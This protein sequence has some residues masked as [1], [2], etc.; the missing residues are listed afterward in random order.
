MQQACLNLWQAEMVM[1]ILPLKCVEWYDSK[2][3][4]VPILKTTVPQ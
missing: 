1:N 4:F 2:H 3:L